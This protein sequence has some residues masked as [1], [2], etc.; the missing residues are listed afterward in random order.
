[1]PEISL[2][3]T[4][5]GAPSDHAG[6][7]PKP[8]ARLLERM[9]RAALGQQVSGRVE[10]GQRSLAGSS[11]R[12]VHPLGRGDYRGRVPVSGNQNR[13]VTGQINQGRETSASGGG[14]RDPLHHGLSLPHRVTAPARSPRH[15]P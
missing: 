2:L 15:A 9:P 14:Q 7:D 4:L 10:D 1:M 8:L 11:H 5:G 6:I 13:L 12:L 3:G